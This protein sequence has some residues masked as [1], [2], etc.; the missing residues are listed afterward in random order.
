VVVVTN[1]GSV[2]LTNAGNDIG[3][4]SVTSPALVQLADKNS[5]IVTDV[6][7]SQIDVKAGGDVTITSPGSV[8]MGV[9]SGQNVSI[10]ANNNITDANGK[11]NNITA[12]V[13]TTL[14]AK[15]GTI[16]TTPTPELAPL[17]QG[18]NT[19][20]LTAYAC[21]RRLRVWCS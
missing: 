17:Y 12:T 2:Q 1:T 10:T 5:I 18:I 3:T 15:T 19:P 21:R 8:A 7:A 16:T 4:I 6:A 11:A 13:Q 14:L 9:I 20:T